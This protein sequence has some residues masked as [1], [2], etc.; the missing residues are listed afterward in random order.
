M[1]PQ[2]T[3][4]I[5]VVDDEPQMINLCKSILGMGG[6]DILP[7]GNGEEALRLLR[8]GTTGVQLALIDIML[9]GMNGVELARRVQALRPGIKVVLMSGYG[10]AEVTKLAGESSNFQ[11]IWK[12]FRADSLLRMIENVLKAP[13]LE[14]VD[15]ATNA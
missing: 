3:D 11:V 8:D 13:V 9:P 2:I 10:P 5:L 12:P 15:A 4:T 1:N 6:Y 14:S 7:A